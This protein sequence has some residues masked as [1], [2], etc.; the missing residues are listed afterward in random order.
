M[1]LSFGGESSSREL[2]ASSTPLVFRVFPAT[3]LVPPGRILLNSLY[4]DSRH[5]RRAAKYDGR[6]WLCEPPGPAPLTARPRTPS[7]T[8]VAVPVASPA[9]LRGLAWSVENVHG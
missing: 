2:P 4:P 6:L 1:G 5:R 3:I 8:G 9:G 7:G